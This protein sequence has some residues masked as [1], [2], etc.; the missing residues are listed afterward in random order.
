MAQD[1][2]DLWGGIDL[3]RASLD[4]MG[5]TISNMQVRRWTYPIGDRNGTGGWIPE[6]YREPLLNST[7][8]KKLGMKYRYFLPPRLHKRF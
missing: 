6:K 3:L 4:E 5:F 8:G 7:S 2:I 1:I